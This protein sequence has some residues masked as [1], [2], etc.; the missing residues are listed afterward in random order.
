MDKSPK[1]TYDVVAFGA[2]PD[3]LE[4]V[5][6]GTAAKLARN[7]FA[8]LFVD[9]CEGEPT[10]YAPRGE[11]HKQAAQAAE[12]LGVHRA[13]L[14]LQDRLI[15]DTIGA[16]IEIA[17]LLREHRPRMVF[18]TSGS[19]VHPDHQA[20]TEIVINGVFYARLPKWEEVP[21][22][23]SLRDFPPHE[24]DRLFFGHC[25]M[26]PAWDRFDFAVDVTDVYD[27]KV[28]ALHAYESVFSGDQATLLD[29]YSAEDRYVGSLVGVRYAESFRAR[30]PLLVAGPE[31]FFKSRFG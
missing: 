30:S 4:A 15:R 20:L 23:E 16:R 26:E 2:H 28:S 10:R 6:G 13:T 5:L 1:R 19:G 24:I 22:G 27:R 9:L 18:A 14:D 12:I 29:K 25:R 8:I 7:K 31:V 3:D 21:G 11:R 17:R